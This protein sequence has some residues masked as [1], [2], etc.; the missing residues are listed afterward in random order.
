MRSSVPQELLPLVGRL[1]VPVRQDLRAFLDAWYK[2]EMERLTFAESEAQLRQAQGAAQV[3]R[4][5]STVL[6]NPEAYLAKPNAS[7]STQLP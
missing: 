1:P 7:R 5:I 2:Q 4:D 3:L 6:E